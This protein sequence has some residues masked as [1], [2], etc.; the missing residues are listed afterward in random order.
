MEIIYELR[1]YDIST[2]TLQNEMTLLLLFNARIIQGYILYKSL[3]PLSFIIPT[4]FEQRY[5]LSPLNF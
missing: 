1:N 2:N 4:M 5:T 3:F